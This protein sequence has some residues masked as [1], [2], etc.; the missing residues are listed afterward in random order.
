MSVPFSRI[1]LAAIG[2]LTVACA[3]AFAANA[4]LQVGGLP[5][6][7]SAVG[8]VGVGHAEIRGRQVF[9]RHPGIDLEA[10]DGKEASARRNRQREQRAP[11]HPFEL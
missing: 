4:P 11:P 10:R 6:G 5:V 1:V 3:S 9:R 8:K 7:V 2:G